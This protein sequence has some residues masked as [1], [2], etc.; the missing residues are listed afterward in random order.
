MSSAERVSVVCRRCTL[1]RFWTQ[2][3]CTENGRTKDSIR[4]YICSSC[5]T[6]CIWMDMHDLNI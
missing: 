2:T 5:L 4:K 1:E 6:K 3:K